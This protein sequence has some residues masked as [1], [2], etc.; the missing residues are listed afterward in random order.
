LEVFAMFEPSDRHRSSQSA[1]IYKGSD[2]MSGRD[3]TVKIF[4]EPYGSHEGFISIADSIATRYRFMDHENL[5]KVYETGKKNDR[6]YIAYEWMPTSLREY[7]QENETCDIAQALSIATQICEGLSY[8]YK[9]K[10]G[11]HMD[12]KPSNILIDEGANRVKLTDHWVAPAMEYIPE[13]ER[14]DW[15]DP[16]Y[17][18]PEQ[19]HKIGDLDKSVD[20]YQIGILL[21]QMLTGFPLFHGSDEEKLRYQQVYASPDKLIT[22]YQQI[23]EV[24]KAIL[25]RCLRK[26]PSA[27][28]GSIEE[29]RDALSYA[30]AGV[31]FKK[32]KPEGSLVG[33]VIDNRF[34]LLEE[35]G[36]GQFSSVYKGIEKGHEK[37]VSVKVYD[38]KLSSEE[39]FIKAI[40]KDLYQQVQIRHPYVVDLITSGWHKDQ[41]YLVY[42]FV[43]MSFDAILADRPTIPPEQG[44]RVILKIASILDYLNEKELIRAHQELKP[45]NI[46]VNP[47]GEDIILR[48][49]RLE[50]ASRVITQLMGSYSSAYEYQA[51]EVIDDESG[52][53]FRADIYSLGC[54]LFRL[55][56][57][58]TPFAADDPAEVMENHRSKE[59]L[60]IIKE[61]KEI[62]LVFHDILAKM[63]EKKPEDR[64]PDY[65]SLIDDITTLIG[66]DTGG[67]AAQLIDVG[68]NIKGKYFIEEKL[69]DLDEANL[70][71]ATHTQTDTQVLLWFY[72]LG[73][74]KELTETF[75]DAMRQASSFDHPGIM[76]HLGWGRDKGAYFIATELRTHT[77]E[78]YVA[79]N[80]P[81][82]EETVL[83]LIKQIIETMQYL[84][85]FDIDYFGCLSPR[86]LFLV[87]KPNMRIKLSGFE[88]KAIFSSVFKLN[89]PSYLSPEQITGLGRMTFAIDIYA[90]GLIAYFLLTGKHLFSGEPDEVSKMQVFV[91][92]P[93]GLTE[94]DLSDEMRRVI[95]KC[96]I[97]DLTA[98]YDSYQDLLD[99]IDDYLSQISGREKEDTTLSFLPGKASWRTVIDTAVDDRAQLALRIPSNPTGIRGVFAICKGHGT[100]DEARNAE[101]L[102][103][104]VIEDTFSFS[105]LSGI[106]LLEN[107]NE[108][109]EQAIQKANGVLNQEAFRL[110]RLGLFGAELLLAV[111]TKNRLHLSRVGTGFA[112]LFRGGNIRTFM[113]R[114]TEVRLL[115]KDMTVRVEATERHLRAGDILVLGTGDLGRAL[116]DVE[117]KN[118]VLSTIDS[119]EACER[120]ISLAASRYKGAGHDKEAMS[121]EVVQFGDV[122]E[123]PLVHA[124]RFASEPV[125]HHYITKGTAYLE[126]GMYD[127]AIQEFQK[128]L[129]IN[130]DAFSLNFQIA[131]AYQG[132]GALDVA[133]RHLNMAME[134]F[135]NFVSG[136][137]KL[138]E[139][140]YQKG[141]IR[142]ASDEFETAVALG[143][144]SPEPYIALG[145]FYYK[146]S[147]FSQAAKAF[148]KALEFD[149][150]NQQAQ[151]NYQM[152]VR[153]AKSITGAIAESAKKVSRGIRAPFQR[154]K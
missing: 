109:A 49:F 59:A 103:M 102:A 83:E 19:I 115:G 84:R 67:L 64:Y 143:G 86:T 117:L 8:A 25:L 122:D 23:P 15:E 43:P 100:E 89:H 93:P 11:P 27:R 45:S 119:Q 124:G 14:R 118:T 154:K 127:K 144:N 101:R 13:E 30:L 91:D 38:K 2:A 111:V 10:L 34:E 55:V 54:I 114:P 48:D 17:L 26:D 46:L 29:L 107:P 128:G 70:Y 37:F 145:S 99:D 125:L 85:S 12:I 73:K 110:N 140:Y 146:E 81:F 69:M 35:L 36:G 20:I 41:F 87:E 76:R 56:T 5:I 139:I 4:K 31:S 78:N 24:V 22:Y 32:V 71:R 132:K 79:E 28:Y 147:L 88:R 65:Q 151:R 72:K 77:V 21:Y 116:A 61:A 52:I 33:E 134:L 94:T 112:Y 131:L 153:R 129:A 62:P 141:Q 42:E 92:E 75:G 149:P 123:S 39:D 133:L 135:P 74:T 9:N 51:P 121:V 142:R 90:I 150:N 80:G 108:L 44:L 50:E 148:R 113:R 7:L 58:R 152:A 3:G 18:A 1:L 68:T 53:D 120:I 66:K 63:L 138:G 105:Y 126:S 47:Q 106:D 57:G 104:Q 60:P 95:R 40:K 6:L 136:H 97:K 98:R 130:P 137:I 96:I 16:R 82:D